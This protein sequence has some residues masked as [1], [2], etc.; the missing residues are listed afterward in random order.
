[1]SDAV[2]ESIP[3]EE[4]WAKVKLNALDPLIAGMEDLSTRGLTSNKK[5]I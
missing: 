1:M 5:I 3:L 2:N 4:G